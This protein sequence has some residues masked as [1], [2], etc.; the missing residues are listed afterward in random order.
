MIR[1]YSES[2]FARLNSD[3]QEAL[4]LAFRSA[5]PRDK[6]LLFTKIKYGDDIT[7][8]DLSEKMHFS[9]ARSVYS[10]YL[11][12]VKSGLIAA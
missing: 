5:P 2:F 12:T 1:D 7:F 11:N 3:I 10:T 6:I 8:K 9:T 4:F